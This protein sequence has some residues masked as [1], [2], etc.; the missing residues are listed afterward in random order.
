MFAPEISLF[1]LVIRNAAK[2]VDRVRIFDHAKDKAD[3]DHLNLLQISDS[4]KSGL[5]NFTFQSNRSQTV[6]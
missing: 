3:N 4:V 6:F 5:N 2:V 1:G